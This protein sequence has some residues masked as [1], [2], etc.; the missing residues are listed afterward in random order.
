MTT[1]IRQHPEKITVAALALVLVAAGYWGFRESRAAMRRL[2]GEPVAVELRGAVHRGEPVPVARSVVANWPKPAPQSGGRGWVYEVFT[3]PAIYYNALARSFTLSPPGGEAGGAL[4]FG[5]ELLGVELEPYRLQLAGYYG[6][7]GDL[8]GAFTSRQV[9]AP[10][11]GRNGRHFPELRLTLR[12]IEIQRIETGRPGPVPAFEVAAVAT[13]FDEEAGQE[14]TLDS[15]AHRLTDVPLAR[16]KLAS[17]RRPRE[18]REGEEFSDSVATYR[19]E[20]VQLDPPEVVISR[21]VAG[22]PQPETKILH[23]TQPGG[24]AAGNPGRPK[25]FPTP[26]TRDLAA[27]QK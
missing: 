6:D 7:S 15:R 23:P 21:T 8:V 14:V 13:L 24:V 16:L 18:V 27:S 19:V 11:F 9:A 12:S 25:H 20:R 5:F 26:A 17:E 22:L 10:L 1:A 2:S 3:P 4:A